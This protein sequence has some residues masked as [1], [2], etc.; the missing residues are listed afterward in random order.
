MIGSYFQEYNINFEYFF[1]LFKF[2]AFPKTKTKTILP[3]FLVQNLRKP[4][5][6]TRAEWRNFK[7][8][9]YL[10]LTFLPTRWL[11]SSLIVSN[12]FIV[13]VILTL[14]KSFLISIYTVSRKEIGVVNWNK[15]KHS[16][17]IKLL[18]FETI[19]SGIESILFGFKNFIRGI[20]YSYDCKIDTIIPQ[21]I[22][23]ATDHYFLNITNTWS[24]RRNCKFNIEVPTSRYL[25]LIKTERTSYNI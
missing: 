5:C 25:S 21:V 18:I 16:I 20:T 13:A 1:K 11:K 6:K 9:S 7:L 14:K 8:S 19:L 12:A 4:R 2:N 17:Q 23:T 3:N 22:L 24:L 15:I 10:T